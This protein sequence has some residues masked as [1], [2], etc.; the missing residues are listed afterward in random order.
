[1]D[2]RGFLKLFATALPVAAVA[3]T[4]FFAP[5][6]G[7]KSKAIWHSPWDTWSYS[8]RSNVEI[9]NVAVPVG[10]DT[11]SGG[12]VTYQMLLDAY[13]HGLPGPD[14]VIL[15]PKQYKAWIEAGYPIG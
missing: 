13:A 7:W 6:G 3:P 10:G 1:M 11:A 5:I 4:Y 14:T 9:Y 2:R 8:P 12:E 15:G